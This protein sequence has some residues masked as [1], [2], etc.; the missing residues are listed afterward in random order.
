[1]K[2]TR[3]FA[4]SDRIFRINDITRIA[5]IL[6][7]QVSDGPDIR[8]WTS[9]E[10][11]FEED[12]TIEGTAVELFTEEELDRP[13]RP[14]K[15][16]MR[17]TASGAA[18]NIRINLQS[19]EPRWPS[20]N[21]VTISADNAD[22]ANANFTALNDAVAQATPRSILWKRHPAFTLSFIAVGFAPAFQLAFLIPRYVVTRF[23]P[24]SVPQLMALKGPAWLEFA[25]YFGTFM[26]AS[27]VGFLSCFWLGL[28]PAYMLRNWLFSMWPSVEFDFGSTRLRLDRKRGRLGWVL[29]VLVIPLILA[30]VYDILKSA[31]H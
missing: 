16:E 11:A 22:W 9:Y 18:R 14:F 12:R 15:I 20:E 6:D 1:M 21:S 23:F 26:S 24:S 27:I 30:A 10:V 7:R 31:I 4:I 13:S 8:I 28:A 2:V 29:T 17:L 19:G 25:V 5:G 3:E